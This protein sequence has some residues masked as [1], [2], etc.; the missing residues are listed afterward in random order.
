MF[1]PEVVLEAESAV[2]LACGDKPERDRSHTLA[3]QTLYDN[4]QLTTNHA[5]QRRSN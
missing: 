5:L 2:E 1:A 3:F 4:P